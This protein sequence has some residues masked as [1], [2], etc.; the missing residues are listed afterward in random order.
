MAFLNGFGGSA[1]VNATTLCLESWDLTV[2]SEKLDS[3]TT[4]DSG[5]E[6]NIGGAKSWEG[7][8]KSYFDAAI[9]Y[10]AA[11]LA[12]TP[13]NSMVLDLAFGASVKFATGIA[14]VTS[15]KFSN[16]V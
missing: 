1:T 5:W 2:N 6:T 15:V 14:R 3:T 12:L 8:L 11:P 16:P 7:T 9:S 10:F 4:C 13:G